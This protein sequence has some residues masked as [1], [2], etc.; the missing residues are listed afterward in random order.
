LIVESRVG[1][2]SLPKFHPANEQNVQRNQVN[3]LLL[4]QPKLLAI[5]RV[6]A[7]L[8]RLQSSVVTLSKTRC[9]RS[10]DFQ[11]VHS[12]LAESWERQIRVSA[13]ERAR[14]VKCL[15]S[16]QKRRS[17]Y[18]SSVALSRRTHQFVQRYC[19][20]LREWS[21]VTSLARKNGAFSQ[22]VCWLEP[23]GGV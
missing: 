12:R 10:V 5:A 18:R 22:V 7:K 19:Y 11:P 2:L 16:R 9:P 21:A 8:S 6:L 23:H 4:Y 17:V 20:D 1:Q 14:Q 15:I 3:G 13:A